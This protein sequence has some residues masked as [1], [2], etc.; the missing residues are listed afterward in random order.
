MKKIMGQDSML[1]RMGTTLTNL[2]ELNLLWLVCCLPIITIGS[3][4][5]AMYYTLYQ[6]IDQKDDAIF[7]PFVRAFKRNFKQSTLLWIPLQLVGGVLAL[8]AAY[9]A[10][11]CTR[12][13][14][15]LWIAFIVLAV[16]YLVI[17]T[18]A[19]AIMA[20]FDSSNRQIIK[21]SLLLAV[22]NLLRSLAVVLLSVAPILVFLFLP[23]VVIKSLP[24][25][26]IVIFG[27]IFF[28]KAKL[29]LQS[30]DHSVKNDDV[31]EGE[32]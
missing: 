29:F 4:T 25:W 6:M 26:V 12:S 16:G 8:D 2:I 9:L 23:D 21:N 3:A 5:T 20:R 10:V 17:T 18:H 14:H 1:V 28:V 24:L 7:A 27:A 30:F 32:A 15:V 19:F 13:F 31:S 22:M 11:N